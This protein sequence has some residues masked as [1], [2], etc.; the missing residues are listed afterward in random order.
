M[1]TYPTF[2]LSQELHE[3]A[4]VVIDKENVLAAVATLR[5]VVRTPGN[6][7]P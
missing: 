3:H 6:H 5:D 7:H 4:P 2:R 1:G